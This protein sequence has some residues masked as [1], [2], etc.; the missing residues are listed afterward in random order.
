MN[1]SDITEFHYIT[2]IGNMKSILDRGILCHRLAGSCQH[3]SVADND[4][5]NRRSNKQIPG[6][7]K[8][9]H[10][11]VN[12]YFD[13]HNPML[14]RLRDKNNSICILQI[15]PD[16][17]DLPEVIVSDMNAARNWA[18]F[19]QVEDGLD[20][21]DKSVVFAVSWKYPDEPSKEDEYKRKKCAEI[22]VPECIGTEYLFGAYV[23]NDL[24]KLAFC[25]VCS[26][27]VEVKPSIFF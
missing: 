14:S 24:A 9:I 18:R 26:L 2:A 3:V 21:I 4:V 17:L 1:R 8:T 11:Y 15:R 20:M 5:Q 12:L 6:T 27:P 22:L 7:S 25:E 10:D 13:A 19:K 16:V 23:A